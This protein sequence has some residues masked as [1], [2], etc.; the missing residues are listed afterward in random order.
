MCSRENGGYGLYLGSCSDSGMPGLISQILTR[1]PQLED[2]YA[3]PVAVYP[4][5][6]TWSS[7]LRVL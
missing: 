4:S 5:E 3:V 1:E 2:E 7:P 6:K